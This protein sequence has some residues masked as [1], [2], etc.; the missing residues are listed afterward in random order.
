LTCDGAAGGRAIADTGASSL[1]QVYRSAFNEPP[2]YHT[3]ALPVSLD[4]M[5]AKV[6]MT[7]MPFAAGIVMEGAPEDC[8]IAMAFHSNRCSQ[9]F[10]G[11]GKNVFHEFFCEILSNGVN[12]DELS[13]QAPG[14]ENH[15]DL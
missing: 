2:L 13:A 3:Q 15:H 11:G 6:W 5:N 8:P 14:Q 4:K 10:F 12:V 7:T 1:D 9:N